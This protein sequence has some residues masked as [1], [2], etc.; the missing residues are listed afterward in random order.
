MIQVKPKELEKLIDDIGLPKSEVARALG[1]NRSSL[2]RWIS[3]GEL[4][5]R[6]YVFL[7]VVRFEEGELGLRN[8]KLLPM[9][10]K[11][12]DLDAY[13]DEIRRDFQTALNKQV[14]ESQPINLSSLDTIEL[15]NELKRRNPDEQVIIAKVRSLS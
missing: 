13:V 7:K 14:G 11:E 6:A 15:L 5:E 9:R 12:P 4:P 2:W 8:I 1:V 3:T 10:F